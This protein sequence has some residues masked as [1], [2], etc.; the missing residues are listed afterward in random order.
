MDQKKFEEY[1]NEVHFLSVQL[2]KSDEGSDKLQPLIERYSCECTAGSPFAIFLEGER[3][4]Y[5]KHY[6]NALKSYLQARSIPFH[7]FFCFRASAHLFHT[8]G[9]LEKSLEF[10]K[11]ALRIFPDDYSTLCLIK[12]LLTEDQQFDDVIEIQNRLKALETSVENPLVL[13]RSMYSSEREMDLETSGFF[14]EEP[15]SSAEAVSLPSTEPYQHHYSVTNR[16]ASM[17]TESDIFSSPKSAHSE[18]AHHLKERLYLQQTETEEKNP[19]SKTDESNFSAFEELKKLAASSPNVTKDPVNRFI[20]SELGIDSGMSQAL[21]EKIKSFQLIQASQ[22]NKYL[23]QAKQRTQQTD[24]C[25]YYLNGWPSQSLAAN[26]YYTVPYFLTEQSR[27]PNGGIFIRWNGKG[28]ALNPGPKFLENFHAQGL[29]L[30]DID[31][32]IVTG[33]QPDTYAD[34]KEI[35]DLNYQLNK[36]NQHLHIIHYYFNHKAFQELSRLLKPHFKQE[37]HTLH[38]LEIFLD[39]PD[40]EKVDLIEG[41]TLNYFLASNREGYLHEDLEAKNE[42]HAKSESSLGIRLEL[43]IPVSQTQDKSSVRIGYIG[44]SAWHPLLAHHLGNCDLLIT[45][46]GNTTPNDFNKISYNQDCLGYYGTYTL[47]E[48]VAPRL[49]LSGEFSGR[50]GDIR[51]EALQKIQNEYYRQLGTTQRQLPV[52]LPA[53]TGLFV[54]LK[55]LKVKCS[56]SNSPVEPSQVRVIKV[57]DAFGR[58]QYLSPHCCYQ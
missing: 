16:E 9:N 49:L 31:F 27:K 51:I 45:S 53:D 44:H 21:E 5:E 48:E 30:H 25:L 26:P 14:S 4:F 55:S 33:S 34:V 13:S 40:V 22:T 17:Q 18:G 56:V 32:V 37:R 28:I 58:L 38:S 20:D 12:Q 35:Y 2:A 11:K 19:F 52:L 43:K 1:L 54:C 24:N 15:L 7:S 8:T 42:R 39:S 47:L 29:H 57:A 50:E 36:V 46:F 23:Q 41:I 10:A 3:L 6:E